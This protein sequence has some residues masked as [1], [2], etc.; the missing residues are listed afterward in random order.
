MTD[1][2]EEATEKS[3][4]R[5]V[6]DRFPGPQWATLFELAKGVGWAGQ[7]GRI[8]VASFGCWPSQGFTRHAFEVKR[9]RGDF[10]RELDNPAKRKW[11]EEGFHMTWFVV[12]AG[13]VQ[14]EEIPEKWGLLMATKTN[15]KLRR[16][17]QAVHRDVGPLKEELALSAIRAMTQKIERHT[18]PIEFEGVQ[19]SRERFNELVHR[20]T[21]RQHDRLT[22]KMDQCRRE[23]NKINY[24]RR[25]LLTPF[26]M[27]ADALELDWHHRRQ[28]ES[29][30]EKVLTQER[31]SHWL[32]QLG[33]VQMRKLVKEARVAHEALGALIEKATE[34]DLPKPKQP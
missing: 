13:L 22:E 14:K 18:L 16:V 20:G 2:P 25:E 6:A 15:T 1:E 30:P 33:K 9:T 31:I 8:D 24:L 17:V 28:I 10:L 19:M 23:R 29:E 32:L 34:D 12:P 26:L 4:E 11:V 5:L 3:L 7:G 21:V 27:I